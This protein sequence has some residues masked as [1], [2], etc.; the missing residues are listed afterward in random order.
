MGLNNNISSVTSI[1]G[2][3]ENAL[4]IA[5]F[6]IVVFQGLE[7]TVTYAND[8]LL[9]VWGKDKSIIG[10]T[11]LQILPELKDQPFPQLL[12]QV[13]E[14]G[15]TQTDSEAVAYLEKNGI[16]VPVYFDYSYTAIRDHQ[17]T[18]IGVLVI[19]RDVTQQVLAKRKAEE[20]EAKFRNT[21]LQVPIAMAVI[22]TPE[23]II[24]T[25]NQQSLKLWGRTA[26]IIG[27][28]VTEVFPEIIQQGFM[29]I[30][31]SVHETG[32]PYFGNEVPVE[33]QN[34][35]ERYRV[36]INF[37]FHPIFENNEVSSIMTVGYDVTELVK[38]RKQAEDSERDA[39]DATKSLENALAKKDEF[40]GL[41][42]HELKTPLTSITGYLQVLERTQT[43]EKNKLFVSKAVQ[44]AKKLNNLVSDLLDV[45]KIEAGKLQLTKEEVNIREVIEEAIELVKHSFNEQEIFFQSELDYLKACIDRNRIEQ[46]IVNLLINAI[47]YSPSPGLIEVKLTSGNQHL[48][49]VVK[50]KGMGIPLD[51]TV[52]IF[53][54]FHR[55]DELNPVISGLGIGLYIS[56][57][58]IN[59]HS[60]KLWVE[61]ELGL[62]SQFY[63]SLPL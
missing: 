59:R 31:K 6:P 46:V 18:I 16:R 2:I 43:D 23:F 24:E 35:T 30:F 44:Q 26:K 39:I 61:S 56:S 42:S 7:L 40:I 34:E 20:S 4:L 60:G 49:V 47:K 14:T 57:E 53:N 22:K 5:P 10:Q 8:A 36:Y 55:V 32:K 9:Q 28:R 11:F 33:L 58:I 52:K 15:V 13:F 29:Q 19:C 54:K 51:Q 3:L 48:E 38:A 12:K 27:K 45:S 1:E 37:V 50:D 41:A 17:Q 25:A 21:V 62:G 63:F